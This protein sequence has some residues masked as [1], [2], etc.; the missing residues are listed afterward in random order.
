MTDRTTNDAAAGSAGEVDWL[1]WWVA[2]LL[3]LGAAIVYFLPAFSAGR[4]IYGSDYLAGGYTF[5]EFIS[6]RFAEGALPKWVPYV[7]GGLPIFANPGSTYH[8]FRFL[9]DLLF[10]P[11]RIFPVIYVLQFALA[12]L[13]AYLLTREL[14][15][16]RW[17]ALLTGL[18]FQFTGLT[19]SYVL[20]GHEGRIIVATLTP[21]VL[22]LLHR[23]VRTGRAVWFAGAGLALGSALLSF[24]IQSS[25]Y[26]LLL[27]AAWG[28]FAIV[29]TRVRGAGAVT[30]RVAMGLGAVA[31]AFLLA[32]VNFL[33]F[34]DYIDQSPRGGDG[35]GYEYSTS[36]SMPP[37][38]ITG[39]ALPEHAGI[40][41]QYQGSNPFKLHTEYVGGVVL[42][43]LLLGLYYNRKDRYWWFFAAAALVALTFSFGGHTPVYRLYY[44]LLPGTRQFRAPSI[45]FFVV[46]AALVTMA[47]LALERLATLRERAMDDD[48]RLRPARYILAGAAVLALL[49]VL[50]A[51]AGP[52]DAHGRALSAGALRLA[53]VTWLAAA[54]LWAWLRRAVPTLLV[55][56]ALAVLT[57]ADLWSVDRRFFETVEGPSIMYA[58]D[59]VVDFLRSQ[60]GRDRAWILP[61]EVVGARSYGGSLRNYLMHHE[62]DQV[63]GEHGNQLQRYNEFLGAGE[64]TYVDW[65]NVLGDLRTLVSDGAPMGPRRRPPFLAA[66]N[67]RYILSMV[68]LPGLTEVHRGRTGLVYEVPGALP[69]AYLVAEAIR[70]PSP[71]GALERMARPDF[72]PGRMAV[73]YEPPPRPLPGGPAGG[74]TTITEYGPDRVVVDARTDRDALLVLADNYYPGWVATVDGD[75]A[76]ILRVNHAFRGVPL[77]PGE[78]TVVFEFRPSAVYRGLW[79]GIGGLFLL[80]AVGVVD[81]ARHRRGAAD[82]A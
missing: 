41:D 2:G 64:R 69:R 42:L 72:D 20:A 74:E 17:I 19:M 29:R 66:G 3:F 61:G 23:G 52:S 73:L 49:L 22:F 70:A 50:A 26:L 58:P 18:A 76:D 11:H 14:G 6:R 78:H 60:P 71:D 35:R 59:D 13:G 57:V 39:L 63:G 24:Q 81:V 56:G 47:G 67:I 16:R 38:E 31:I 51:G 43:L 53:V 80:V 25:Y 5:H 9:G 34:L 62:L 45:S 7:Y 27:G 75:P 30:G 1:S 12:G 28:I 32:A 82:E 8:P 68:E 46:S 48:A 33:P 36:W 21:L 40:L 79:L 10:E 15:V 4:Q 77:S 37:A 54:V 65:H 55:L 44:A